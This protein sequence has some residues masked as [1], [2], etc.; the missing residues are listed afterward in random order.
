MNNYERIAGTPQLLAH[1]LITVGLCYIT[2][3]DQCKD[4]PLST[5]PCRNFNGLV[6]WLQEECDD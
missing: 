1:A 4:C 3:I 5:A 6:S 2:G